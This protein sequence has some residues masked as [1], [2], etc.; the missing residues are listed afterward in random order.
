MQKTEHPPLQETER[1]VTDWL[2]AVAGDE[3][4]FEARGRRAKPFIK[5][6]IPLAWIQLACRLNAATL[7]IYIQWKAGL[8][9]QKAKI[10][11]RPA[12]LAR[13]GLGGYAR[14][15]QYKALVEAKL[16]QPVSEKGRCKAVRLVRRG[17]G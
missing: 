12:E 16:V 8:L 10:A 3:P 13:F 15:R 1:V 2:K 14:R 7:A 6:P 4:I 5:G 17:N 11:L 9:G